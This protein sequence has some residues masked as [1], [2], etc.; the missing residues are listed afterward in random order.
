[1]MFIS[2]RVINKFI[3][4][5]NGIVY[6]EIIRQFEITEGPFSTDQL[7]YPICLGVFKVFLDIFSSMFWGYFDYQMIEVGHLT[8]ASLKTILFRKNFR[9]SEATNKDFSSGE[10]NSIIMGE[11]G[12][13]WQFVWSLSDY[14][15]C[16]L[17]IML[18]LYYIYY[19]VGWC[20]VI[21]LISN[22]GFMYYYKNK[23]DKDKEKRNKI[24]KIDD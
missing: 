3:D 23:G 20:S 4:I 7:Y 8:Q 1:M 2:V 24:R 15:E 17:D 22:L 14:F 11:T 19:S 12:I 9:M 6:L 10:I 16:P 5:F 18:G 13:V 21:A